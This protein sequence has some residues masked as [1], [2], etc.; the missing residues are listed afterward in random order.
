LFPLLRAQGVHMFDGRTWFLT[1]AHTESDVDVVVE[2]FRN[3]MTE[4][5]DVGLVPRVG[6][7]AANDTVARKAADPIPPVPNAR[8]GRDPSGQPGWYVPDPDRPGKYLLVEEAH[9]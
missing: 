9:S 8:L 6:P 5:L 1:A 7:S 3:A 4:L 2:A